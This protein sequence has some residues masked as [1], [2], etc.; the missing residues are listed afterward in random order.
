VLLKGKP[1]DAVFLKIAVKLVK[2]GKKRFRR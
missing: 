1:E 2:Y